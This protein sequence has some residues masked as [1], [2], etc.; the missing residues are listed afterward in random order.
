MIMIRISDVAGY[1][2]RWAPVS[3]AESYDN[4]GLLVGNPSSS[5][6]K[7]LVSLDCTETVVEEAIRQGC[8]L[9]V[10][11]HPII[12]GGLKQL[13]GQNNI[14]RTVEMAIK[15]DIGLIAV[16]TNLDNINTGVN[17]KIADVLGLENG[18]VLKPAKG[19]LMAITWF[20]PK[21][22][23]LEVLKRVNEAGAG[24]IGNY[25]DCS[26]S[27]TGIGRFRPN[28]VARPT[29]GIAGNLEELE[30]IKSEVVCPDFL[31]SGVLQALFASHPYE[32]V[33]YFVH[34]IEN[35]N[36]EIGSGWFGTLPEEMPWNIFSHHLKEKFGLSGFRHTK[37]LKEKVRNVALCGGSGHFLL[38][39]AIRS[40]ADIFITA[41]IKYHQFFDADGKI[42]LIDLGHF[43]SEQFTSDLIIEKLSNQFPNIAVLLSQVRTNPVFYA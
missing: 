21:E 42:T 7:I 3:L 26:F 35:E 5:V 30:E 2:H 24:Q 23:H 39:E 38:S 1:L 41:D 27:S 40:G 4:V 20:T 34:R 17:R 29:I 14:S 43:E 33:A 28:E 18:R 15:N 25:S 31:L 37:V 8:N 13:T 36:R 6:S 12:F 10:S 32:E 19:R 22:H 9:I 11:H 16:H